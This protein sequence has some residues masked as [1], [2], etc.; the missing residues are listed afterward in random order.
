MVGAK[1]AG[2]GE[3]I[4]YLQ[5]DDEG[6]RFNLSLINDAK[7]STGQT[8]ISGESSVLFGGGDDSFQIENIGSRGLTSPT[9]SQF[10]R[11][12]EDYTIEGYLYFPNTPAKDGAYMP[13]IYNLDHEDVGGG[14][15]YDETYINP[16]NNNYLYYVNDNEGGTDFSYICNNTFA[17]GAWKHFAV[18]KK[19][20]RLR[21]FYHGDPGTNDSVSH[22]L[23]SGVNDSISVGSYTSTNGGIAAYM[24]DFRI[25]K[26]VGKYPFDPFNQRQTLTTSTSLQSGITVTASNTKLLCCHHSTITTDGSSNQTITANGTTAPA[27][28]N[29]APIGGMKSAYFVGGTGNTS[30][31]TTGSTADFAF[32]TGDATIELWA[33]FTSVADVPW[34]VDFTNSTNTGYMAAAQYNGK[35]RVY[36]IGGSPTYYD[37]NTTIVTNKW[38][39]IALARKSQ[40]WRLFVN[41]LDDGISWND[42]QDYGNTTLTI[43]ARRGNTNNDYK[44]KGYI[45]NL[46]VVKG[47]AI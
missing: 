37:G 46:R 19:N 28:S 42:S 31:L 25:T 17:S 23:G 24:A 29:F 33:Y 11:S 6:G 44:L 1:C 10:F 35:I 26:G 22:S 13:V 32:G 36:N 12:S 15:G 9:N 3:L 39:H 4:C 21:V 14:L 2:T 30:S 18:V 40:T 45:S 41:G 43:G 20:E 5:K 8:R 34:L 27:V 47:Q 16:D 7:S 38:Y